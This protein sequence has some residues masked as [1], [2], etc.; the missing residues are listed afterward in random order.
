MD[1]RTWDP[2]QCSMLSPKTIFYSGIY[3]WRR[4][5]AIR[6]ILYLVTSTF[7]ACSLKSMQNIV[8]KPKTLNFLRSKSNGIQI[9]TRN[10]CLMTK[11]SH[12]L[13]VATKNGSC[14]WDSHIIFLFTHQLGLP[15][16]MELSHLHCFSV[17]FPHNIS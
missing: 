9:S 16:I 15:K 13:K 14:G 1:D 17:G 12:R 2:H 5:P 10:L 3:E 6:Q 7:R 4:K 11:P 8:H